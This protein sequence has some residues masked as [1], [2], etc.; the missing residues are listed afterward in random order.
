M[1]VVSQPPNPD[2]PLKYLAMIKIILDQGAEIDL[3]NFYTGKALW[4]AAKLGR[5]ESVEALLIHDADPSKILTEGFLTFC[6][7]SEEN[8]VLLARRMRILRMLLKAGGKLQNGDFNINPVTYLLTKGIPISS[9]R[10]AEEGEIKLLHQEFEHKNL[11]KVNDVEIDRIFKDGFGMFIEDVFVDFMKNREFLQ[12]AL[13]Y[14]VNMG[15]LLNYACQ[16]TQENTQEDKQDTAFDYLLNRGANVNE[17]DDEGYSPLFNVIY[18]DHDISRKE[19]MIAN[20][21]EKK[22]NVNYE[23]VSSPTALVLVC[24][25][26]P[27][28][29]TLGCKLSYLNIIKMLLKEGADIGPLI[30]LTLQ[31]DFDRESLKDICQSLQSECPSLNIVLECLQPPVKQ[32]NNPKTNKYLKEIKGL[33]DSFLK[34]QDGYSDD[35]L[36]Y[37]LESKKKENILYKHF[38]KLKEHSNNVNKLSKKMAFMSEGLNL[39]PIGVDKLL[40]DGELQSLWNQIDKC[41]KEIEK[42]IQTLYEKLLMNEKNKCANH[43]RKYEEALLVLETQIQDFENPK[44]S[45]VLKD[46]DWG[47]D[48]EAWGDNPGE[49]EKIDKPEDSENPNKSVIVKDDDWGENP[50]EEKMITPKGSDSDDEEDAIESEENN[51]SKAELMV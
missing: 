18:S 20:L 22:A 12:L 7:P 2:H 3:T 23:N 45:V 50:E 6:D 1:E 15:R 38:C 4:C 21:L 30:T 29:Y 36:E 31:D 46:D 47:D 9:S 19:E 26:Y 39:A 28:A 8:R 51:T 41:K 14:N 32:P 27:L 34:I 44:K 49:E 33:K 11:K 17:V 42:S 13:Y 5:V 48:S 25:Q 40:V 24:K 43:K 10:E 16:D 37:N 35:A